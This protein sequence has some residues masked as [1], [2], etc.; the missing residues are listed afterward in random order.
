M[1]GRL[2]FA[3]AGRLG[4]AALGAGALG[5]AVLGAGAAQAGSWT[6]TPSLSTT[7]TFTDNVLSVDDGAE[8]DTVNTTNAGIALNG[9]GGRTQAN[10]NYNLS[11]DTYADHSELDGF[12]HSMLGAGSIDLYEEYLTLDA[13]ASVSESIVN[14][15]GAD[16]ASD[17]TST[18]RTRVLNY[19]FSPTFR[20]GND[21]WADSILSYTFSQVRTFRTAVA[22]T[23]GALPSSYT[24]TIN[25]SLTSGRRFSVFGWGIHGSTVWSYTSN[26]FRSRRD[27][28]D[29]N[30]SYRFNQF[31]TLTASAGHDKVRDKNNPNDQNSGIFWRAGV[32]LTPSPRT[33]LAVQYG[34]RYNNENITG[35]FS[36]RFSP[37][38]SVQGSYTVSLQTQQ[39]AL[40]ASLNNLVFN[41]QGE[42]VDADTGLPVDFTNFGVTLVDATLRTETFSLGLN[43]SRGRNSFT[44]STNF[45]KRDIG[46]NGGQDKNFALNGSLSRRLTPKANATVR[47]AYSKSIPA[48]VNS[49]SVDTYTGSAS[50]AYNFSNDL[51]GTVDYNLV[52]RDSDVS[53]DFMENVVAV[54]LRKSF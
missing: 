39:E 52:V 43:G 44:V 38:T 46:S 31:V 10:F 19:G 29:V 14:Q 2:G 15:A 13:R 17:R 40:A 37:Q 30:G 54:R 5:M 7:Q 33:S 1:A 16:T 35:N 42:L 9:R 51:S 4:F 18:N 27:S 21:G 12:R 25:S 28:L 32:N 11:R 41:D 48:N 22:G 26:K 36:Y 23:S 50:Y 34:H 49:A 20:H 45:T 8:F 3:V 24:H 6:I 47:A 53:N